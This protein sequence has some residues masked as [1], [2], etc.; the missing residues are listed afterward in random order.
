MYKMQSDLYPLFYLD[1]FAASSHGFAQKTD[2]ILNFDHL[3][4]GFIGSSGTM[5]N[6]RPPVDSQA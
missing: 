5:R 6:T 3:F 1:L 4:G 2:T